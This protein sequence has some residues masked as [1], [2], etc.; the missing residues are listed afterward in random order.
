MIY[1]IE[2]SDDFI[3]C[4]MFTYFYYPTFIYPCHIYLIYISVNPWVSIKRFMDMVYL[5]IAHQHDLYSDSNT[6]SVF[7]IEDPT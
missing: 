2:I 6:I 7:F 5:T 3:V 1:Q 4:S